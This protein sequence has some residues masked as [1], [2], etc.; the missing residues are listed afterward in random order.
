MKIWAHRGCSQMY[1]EN[2]I[3]AFEKAM[4]IS[5][6]A[7]IELDIQLTRDGEMVV[8][9]DEKLD[10]TTNMQG[11]VRDYS[12][13]EIK[14]TKIRTVD[15]SEER[16]P[17]MREVLDLLATKLRAYVSEPDG[18]G[19]IRLNIELKNG[20]YPYPGMEE[21]IVKL[22]HEYGVQDAIIYSSFYP[23]SLMIIHQLDPNAEIGVLN[24]KLSNCLYTSLGMEELIMEQESK[25]YPIALHPSGRGLD[26]SAEAVTGRTV[27]AYFGG[28][29][30]P[31]P[32][33]GG[34]MDL[35][36]LEA[37][38]VTDVFLNEPEGYLCTD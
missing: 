20:I 30:Y 19:G 26:L 32:P 1:P 12:L 13:A 6:L 25:L 8:I 36:A 34:I 37:A 9:H 11:Y 21:R 14:A 2:T 3:T 24:G 15:G 7:G 4:V 29:L 33:T 22:V 17:T 31:E 27:R 10:R 35:A 23:K 28:H 5:G 38:G 16:I 18:N